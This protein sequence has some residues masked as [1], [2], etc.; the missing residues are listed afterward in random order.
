MALRRVPSNGNPLPAN[1]DRSEIVQLER[2][3]RRAAAWRDADD[4]GAVIAPSEMVQ[5]L[6]DSRIIKMNGRSRH[7]INRMG[8]SCLET[9]A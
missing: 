9:V 8:L 1:G 2:K 3:N 4:S 5:P 7:W 6:M